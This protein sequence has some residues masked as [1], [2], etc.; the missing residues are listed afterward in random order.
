L[1]A[2]IGGEISLLKRIPY[3]AGLGGGSGNA[4]AVLAAL[5]HALDP[6]GEVLT[7]SQLLEMAKTLG[8]DVPLFAAGGAAL[9][10]GIGERVTPLPALQAW[11]VLAQP[12]EVISTPASYRAWDSSGLDSGLATAPLLAAWGNHEPLQVLGGLL[13]NDL[14]HSASALGVPVEDGLQALREAGAAG[15]EMTGSGSA[16]FGL[17]HDAEHAADVEAHTRCALDA[18]APGEWR[19]WKAPL[20]DYGVRV[21]EGLAAWA[22]VQERAE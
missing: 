11:V 3:G 4:W 9:I 7:R 5:S 14:R 1:P 18:R 17:C 16:V 13:G 21:G 22:S 8:A 15:A 20:C 12:R 10:E 19:L 2:G 6:H